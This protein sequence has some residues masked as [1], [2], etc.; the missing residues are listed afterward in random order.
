METS[1]QEKTKRMKYK[2]N[3]ADWFICSYVRRLTIFTD[4]HKHYVS[5]ALK[6]VT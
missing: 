2:E 5:I 1:T 3:Q 6:Y 4:T